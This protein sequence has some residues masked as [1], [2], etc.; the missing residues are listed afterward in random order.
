MY[1]ELVGD[2][3]VVSDVDGVY[4]YAQATRKVAW[5][6]EMSERVRNNLA[7]RGFFNPV[8]RSMQYC[9]PK[10]WRSLML[11]LTTNCPLACRYC[12]AR[13]G[14]NNG[15]MS[16]EIA[17][18]AVTAYLRT[19]PDEPKVT[20]FGAGEPT[21]NARVIKHVVE[22]YSARIRWSVTTSGVMNTEFL[23]WLIDHDIG[24]TVSMDGPPHIQNR[25]RPLRGGGASAPIVEQTV[26]VLAQVPGRTVAV[27]ATV[28]RETLQEIDRVLAYFQDLGVSTVHLEGMYS[29]G[30]A[31]DKQE[32]ALNPLDL[33]EMLQMVQEG[34]DWARR[35]SKRLKIGGLTYLLTPRNG[36]YCG[37]MSGQMMVVNHLGQLTACSE[38]G[39]QW[40]AGWEFFS[41]GRI[42][43]QG[44]LIVDE[45]RLAK[46]QRRIVSHMTP[47]RRC[48][49]RYICRGGCAHK[50]WATT[51]DIYVPDPQYCRFVQAVVPVL[52]KRMVNGGGGGHR[53]EVK[54]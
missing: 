54:R 29:L 4:L 30:R 52:L 27:R 32:K 40:T 31:L 35:T 50:A 21:L 19:K 22:K 8:P 26:R 47:C 24:V 28:T 6:R 46:C 3:I 33:P 36:H 34:L 2:T 49:A 39:N 44:E 41:L 51:G 15:M 38:V 5:V 16:V 13:G 37:P 53:K 25:L 18:R 42:G 45:E 20:F 9:R 14:E 43:G 12:Y 11:L 23:R 7:G 48:F 10:R 1:A 17:E